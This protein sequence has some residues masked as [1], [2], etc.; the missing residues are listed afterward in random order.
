MLLLICNVQKTVT[1][2]KKKEVEDLE[3]RVK[4]LDEFL[5]NYKDAGMT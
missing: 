5:E 2:E 3:E 1:E 4:L